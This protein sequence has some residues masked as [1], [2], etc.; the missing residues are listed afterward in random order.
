M[1][2]AINN[3]MYESLISFANFIGNRSLPEY[4]KS[5][6]MWRWWDNDTKSYSFATTE[7]LLTEWTKLK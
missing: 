4:S 1:I 3:K 2:K 6:N 7:E 5:T